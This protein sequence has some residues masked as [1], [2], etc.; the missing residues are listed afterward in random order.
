MPNDLAQAFADKPPGYTGPGHPSDYRPVFA[1]LAAKMA[2]LGAL[3][4]DFAEA[5]GVSTRTI[6]RW[7][8]TIPEFCRAIKTEQEGATN[9][10]VRSLFHRACGYTVEVR[11]AFYDKNS[12]NVLQGV[13]DQHFPP[14]T[15]AAAF[16]LKN[17][18]PA[19]WRD[20]REIDISGNVSVTVSIDLA[21]PSSAP[22]VID[23]TAV[24][25]ASAS[26]S[27]PNT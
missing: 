10:V 12:G 13:E 27:E 14:D 16:W 20:R 18:R 21:G 25:E 22:A 2:K 24:I 6:E 9:H 4:T 1:K 7:R 17:K 5:F 26:D 19:E 3:D 23:Q 11:K 8:A 15:G